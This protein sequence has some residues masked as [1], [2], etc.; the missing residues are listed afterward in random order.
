MSGIVY[1][2]TNP[3][4]RVLELA[5][6]IEQAAAAPASGKHGAKP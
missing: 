6:A 4:I 1:V 5:E 3:A 2:L